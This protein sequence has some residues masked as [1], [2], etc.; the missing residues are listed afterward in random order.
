M[1]KIITVDGDRLDL[2]CWKKYGS[3]SGRVVERVL[4]TNPEIA[5]TEIFEAGRTIFLPEIDIRPREELLW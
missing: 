1:D 3:T 4:E 5:R 2:I